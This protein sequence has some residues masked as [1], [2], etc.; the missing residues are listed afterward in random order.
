[1]TIIVV[2][3]RDHLFFQIMLKAFSIIAAV[4]IIGGVPFNTVAKKRIEIFNETIIMFVLYNII[5]FSPFNSNQDAKQGIGY[6]CCMIVASHLI[7]NL[8][9][10]LS[11]QVLDIRM[12]A[13]IWLARRKLT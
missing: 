8:Y 9:L 6:F 12:K 10:I 11:T 5:C 7:F 3:M 1:M 13:K 4:I 2:V